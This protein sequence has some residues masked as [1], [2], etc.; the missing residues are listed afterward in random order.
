MENPLTGLQSTSS[1]GSEWSVLDAAAGETVLES[2]RDAV[3]S[4]DISSRF[5]Q[6]IIAKPLMGKVFRSWRKLSAERGGSRR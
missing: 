4:I 2:S 5:I 6:R 1:V 3:L